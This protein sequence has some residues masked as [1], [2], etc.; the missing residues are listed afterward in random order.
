MLG[1]AF[2][3]ITCGSS[4]LKCTPELKEKIQKT[5]EQDVGSTNQPA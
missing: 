3:K 5:F 2:P 1:Y 4:M